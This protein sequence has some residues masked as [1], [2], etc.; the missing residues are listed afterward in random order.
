MLHCQRPHGEIKVAYGSYR[1]ED[2]DG[3]VACGSNLADLDTIACGLARIDPSKVG[4][5]KEAVP[6]YGAYDVKTASAVS[7]SSKEWFKSLA[8]LNS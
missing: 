7:Y 6:V 4:Y 1:V 2:G 5:I 3:F 8:A